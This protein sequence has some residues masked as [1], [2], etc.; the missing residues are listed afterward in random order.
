MK[1]ITLGNN[2]RFKVI[3]DREFAAMDFARASTEFISVYLRYAISYFSHL[4]VVI[5]AKLCDCAEIWDNT[6]CLALEK[7]SQLLK[8]PLT[9]TIIRL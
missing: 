3:S 7:S 1:K 6:L 8:G 2:Q 5:A 9:D 4:L